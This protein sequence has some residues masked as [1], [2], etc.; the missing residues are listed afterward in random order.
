MPLI[1]CRR[2]CGHVNPAGENSP[3]APAA[4]DAPLLAP[5]Q[6]DHVFGDV[7][8]TIGTA[9]QLIFGGGAE[10]RT[11]MNNF[12]KTLYTLWEG[13]GNLDFGHHALNTPVVQ[14]HGTPERDQHSHMFG[15]Y[16]NR[17][18]WQLAEIVCMGYKDGVEQ[19]TV[20]GATKA[21]KKNVLAR[22]DDLLNNLVDRTALEFY[23][24]NP[25]ANI[26]Q[27]NAGVHHPPIS[28][29]AARDYA[30]NHNG[31]GKDRIA[32]V[33]TAYGSLRTSIDSLLIRFEARRSWDP[34]RPSNWRAYT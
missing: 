12:D 31:V 26:R 21:W 4:Q 10:W 19:R 2:E 11:R 27:A 15:G 32:E 16:S 28:L 33:V 23:I 3:G 17:L 30:N 14:R 18:Q 7:L 1:R 9:W 5:E 29:A 25:A 6:G 24:A 34:S 22:L 20:G 8:G 13:L